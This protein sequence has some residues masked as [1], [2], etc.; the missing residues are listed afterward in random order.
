MT[1]EELIEKF[2][3]KELYGCG[4]AKLRVPM[5]LRDTVFAEFG[6]FIVKRNLTNALIGDH[7][8]EFIENSGRK[9]ADQVRVNNS[10]TIIVTQRYSGSV[11]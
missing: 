2:K 5:H 10:N 1:Q 11:N 9:V 7:M 3:A 4:R 6:A 8:Q